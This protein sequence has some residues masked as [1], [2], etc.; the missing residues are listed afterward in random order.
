M[1]VTRA[2]AGNMVEAIDFAETVSA[3]LV[4]DDVGQ[5][6]NNRTGSGMVLISGPFEKQR[7]EYA[8]NG[9]R[10]Y[11]K[12][13]TCEETL[14]SEHHVYAHESDYRSRFAE[15][16]MPDGK[17]GQTGSQ[18]I[19]IKQLPWYCARSTQDPVASAL[20]DRD[21]AI[22][23]PRLVLLSQCTSGLSDS[24]APRKRHCFIVPGLTGKKGSRMDWEQART[25]VLALTGWMGSRYTPPP[26]SP[27]YRVSNPPT[28]FLANS[29][30][31][32][33]MADVHAPSLNRP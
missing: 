24:L 9:P 20:I 13:W 26:A 30:R 5:H 19:S 4:D 18:L 8:T 22:N 17:A 1:D 10:A 6:G 15:H 23:Y 31:R 3:P 2:A 7:S 16:N 21:R 14:L 25:G 29:R 12:S 28:K 27:E 32:I 33:K 11:R